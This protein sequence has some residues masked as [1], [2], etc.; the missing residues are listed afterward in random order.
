MCNLGGRNADALEPAVVAASG[1]LLTPL[2]AVYIRQ[3]QNPA[4]VQDW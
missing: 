2:L 4:G 1:A 3:L